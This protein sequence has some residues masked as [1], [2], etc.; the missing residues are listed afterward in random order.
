VREAFEILGVAL[1][2]VGSSLVAVLPR[3]LNRF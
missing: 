3:R 2:F 1:L